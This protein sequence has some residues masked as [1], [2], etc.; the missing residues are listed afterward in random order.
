MTVLGEPLLRRVREP[1]PACACSCGSPPRTRRTTTGRLLG[2]DVLIAPAGFW[3]DGQPEVIAR[4]RL[5]Y[6]ADPANPRLRDGTLTVGDLRALPHAAARLPHPGAD[7]AAAALERLGITPTWWSPRAAGCRWRSSS[8]A[9]TWS[10]PYPSGSPAGSRTPPESPSPSRPAPAIELIEAAWWHPMRA[11]DPAL[12]WLR[13][14]LREIAARL[15]DGSLDSTALDS[16]ALDG[17]S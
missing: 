12:T 11:T 10:P 8:P 7:P 15:G 14:T 2:Y 9:P 4:D 16:T 13:T 5:V 17:A 3:A 6:V 1:R